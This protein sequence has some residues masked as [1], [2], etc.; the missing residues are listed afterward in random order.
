MNA[1][2]LATLGRYHLKRDRMTITIQGTVG[3]YQ[4]TLEHTGTGRFQ[5][6]GLSALY[7]FAPEI[8]PTSDRATGV[9]AAGGRSQ[10]GWLACPNCDGANRDPKPR[11]R[12]R[13]FRGISD[14]RRSWRTFDRHRNETPAAWMTTIRS[15]KGNG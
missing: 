12:L 8:Y 3:N 11:S 9:G 6:R 10:A 14:H 1:S 2:G 5:F 4:E 13:H 15:A 7:A